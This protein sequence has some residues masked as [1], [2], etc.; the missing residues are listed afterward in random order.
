MLSESMRDVPQAFR[1][2]LKV[3]RREP[4]FVATLVLTLAVGIGATTAALSVAASVLLSPLPIKDESRLLLVNK[5]LPTGSTLVPFSYA[6]ISAWVEASRTLEAVG[7]VQYDGAWPWTADLGDRAITVTGTAVSGNFFDVL[8]AQPLLGRLLHAEDAVTGAEVVAV[9]GYGLWRHHFGS[10]PAVVGQTVRLD[11]RPARIIGVAPKGFAFPRGADIWRPLDAAPDTI[12]EGWFSLVARLKPGTTLAQAT[13][14]SPALLQQLR[15]IA[16]KGQPADLRAVTMP[17]KDAIVGDVRPVLALLIAAATLLFLVS[18]LNVA[19]LLL[20]RSTKRERETA[21]RA[22]LGASRLRLIGESIAESL[23]LA[24]AGGVLGAFAAF[25]LLRALV[26]GAPAGLPRLDQVTFDSRALGF[27]AAGTLL[28][29][30]LAGVGPAL[31]TV[32][33]SMFGHLRSGS[34]LDSGTRGAQVKSQ[35]LITL[36]LAF[37]LMV[38]VA[39]AL[40]VRSVQQLQRAELGFSPDRLTVVPIPLVGPEYRDPERRRQFFDQLVSRMEVVPGIAA[41]TPV[42][43]RPFTGTDGWDATFTVE[44]QGREEASVNAGLHLEAVLPNYFSTMGIPIRRGRTF[45]DTDGERSLPVV[46]VSESLARRAWPTSNALGKRLKFGSPEQSAPWMTVVGV[47][48]HLRYRDLQAPPPA[49]YVPLPQ[50]PFP[51]RF[52][53][54]RASVEDAPVL[55]ITRRVVREIAPA[56]PVVEAASIDALLQGELAAPRFYTKAIGV[57]ALLAVV[58]AAVGVFAILA[59]FVAQRSGELG[60][61]VALGATPNNIRRFVLARMAWPTTLGLV[62]GTAAV[63]VGSQFLQPLLFAVS[64]LDAGAFATGWLTLGAAS[65]GAS[66]IPSQ[67]ATRVNPISLLRPD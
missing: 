65:L 8:G 16:P 62:L 35:V 2:A 19:N 13:Q 20:V 7:G 40:L 53:M 58:L 38:T 43:L 36:Q 50:T 46:I 54:V 64:A 66:L 28:G 42:L 45:A 15:G 5:T 21:V 17:F 60:V 55:A 30:V 9:I 4:R 63:L 18:C 41:A 57:F 48:G 51:A 39:A 67:R 61:R 32:R 12:N 24:V 23:S 27:A 31:W 11:G 29:A 44:G 10:N 56:E 25:W 22:A 52:L 37:A 47:V 26:A 49:I 3:V 1:Q 59:T 6:E 33:A 34:T 14:E